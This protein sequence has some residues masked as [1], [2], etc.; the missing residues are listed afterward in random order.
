M[1]NNLTALLDSGAAPAV[2]DYESISTVTVGTAQATISFTSIPSTYTHLQLRW[3]SKNTSADYGVRGQ[4]N[5]DTAA[6][7]SLHGLYGTGA[8]AG[9]YSGVSQTYMQFGQ[10]ADTTANIFGVG[11]V[12]I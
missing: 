7:Y 3:M 1:L 6:N 10:G 8:T 12:D 9:A 5:G 2:G 4:F 11:I